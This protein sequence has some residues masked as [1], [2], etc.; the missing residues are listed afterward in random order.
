MRPIQTALDVVAVIGQ[1]QPVGLSA[2]VRALDLPKTTV[3][4]ALRSLQ[5]A[6]WIEAD[7]DD[8]ATWSLTLKAGLAV[9]HAQRATRRLRG[10]AFPIMEELR[11][12]TGESLYL[13]VRDGDTLA[14]VERL[15]GRT[16]I[17]HAWPLWQRGP[18]HATSLGKSILAHFTE[19]EL[20]HYLEAPL[21][22]PTRQTLADPEALRAELA[23]VRER[24]FATSF[25][26]N[27]PNENGVG[28]AIRDSRGH[29]TAAISISAP[30]ERVG[31]QQCV[32]WGP[33][34]TAAASRISLGLTRS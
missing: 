23:V 31:E 32:E 33:L 2:I 22:R 18:L 8:R 21:Q 16:P 5:A 20:D 6:G 30:I 26:E 10:A 4:R 11:S 15:D 14:L 17:A 1:Q 3:H 29:P 27:W 19:A 9:G 12:R 7:H 24:G 25:R 13:A 28:A 34:L